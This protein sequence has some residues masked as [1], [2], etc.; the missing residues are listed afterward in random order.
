MSHQ[1]K[2]NNTA[3]FSFLEFESFLEKSLIDDIITNQYKDQEKPHHLSAEEDERKELLEFLKHIRPFT[4]DMIGIEEGL[5]KLFHSEE[6]DT[7]N[8]DNKR[9]NPSIQNDMETE[10]STG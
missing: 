3:D 7:W 5:S 8:D 10:P 1:T 4:L 2:K 6:R 9:A